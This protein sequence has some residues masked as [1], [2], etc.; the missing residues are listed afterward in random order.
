MSA[1]LSIQKAYKSFESILFTLLLVLSKFKDWMYL[2]MFW[3]LE[4]GS[5]ATSFDSLAKLTFWYNVGSFS[6]DVEM[7]LRKLCKALRDLGVF[8]NKWDKLC[9]ENLAMLFKIA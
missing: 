2:N 5:S 3:L 6:I 1:F 7:N 4:F 8:S 9:F